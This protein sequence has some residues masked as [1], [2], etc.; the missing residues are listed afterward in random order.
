MSKYVYIG[1][2]ETKKYVKIGITGNIMRR[3]KEIQHMNPTFRMLLYF[4]PPDQVT[5]YETE[6]FLHSHFADKRV[7]GE[8][9]NLSIDDLLVFTDGK[10]KYKFMSLMGRKS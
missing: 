3:Q 9:F 4:Q 10:G 5:A 7:I 8:W 2:D 6:K 1:I